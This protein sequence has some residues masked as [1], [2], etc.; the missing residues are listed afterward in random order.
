MINLIEQIVKHIEEID[1]GLNKIK[2]RCEKNAA[3]ATYGLAWESAYQRLIQAKS[4]ALVALAQA[5][6]NAINLGY[7]D[8]PPAST[9]IWRR[10]TDPSKEA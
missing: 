2:E 1:D 9:A 6:V 4:T 10:K 7:A 3:Y 8:K 5:K